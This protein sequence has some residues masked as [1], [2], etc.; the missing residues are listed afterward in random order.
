MNAASRDQI[1]AL[2][3]LYAKWAQHSL[4]ASGDGRADRLAWASEHV[5]RQVASFKSLSRDEA[6]DLI[7]ILKSSFGQSVAEPPRPWRHIRSRDRAHAA[8]TAGRRDV[9]SSVIQMAS[10]DDLARIDQA[11]QRLNWTSDQYRAWLASSRSPLKGSQRELKTVAD[12]N[13]VW[14]A[15]KRMLIRKGRWISDPQKRTR[16]MEAPFA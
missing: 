13:R 12:A 14:W 16:R 2:Q 10:S 9:A 3:A 8:G 4:P 1:I 7:D 15:L 11:L 6:R 5:G